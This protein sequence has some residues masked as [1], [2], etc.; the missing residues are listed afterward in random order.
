MQINEKKENIF[1]KLFLVEQF[2]KTKQKKTL[3][4]ISNYTQIYTCNVYC[5]P[6]HKN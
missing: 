5:N 1:N 3:I 6:K 2:L 4:Y